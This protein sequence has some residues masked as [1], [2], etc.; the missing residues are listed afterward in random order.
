MKL[1]NHPERTARMMFSASSREWLST[2]EISTSIDSCH[3]MVDSNSLSTIEELDHCQKVQSRDLNAG[4]FFKD[5][6]L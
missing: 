4:S 6:H 3:I 2:I 5:F 1:W